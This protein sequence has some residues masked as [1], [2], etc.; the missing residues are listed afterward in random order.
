MANWFNAAG[1]GSWNQGTD[2]ALG[3]LVNPEGCECKSEADPATDIDGTFLPGGGTDQVYC[4][5][6]QSHI[7]LVATGKTGKGF[8][9]KRGV[10]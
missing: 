5:N 8:G 9:G 10:Q 6:P 4:P 1:V 2:I 7:N 3:D